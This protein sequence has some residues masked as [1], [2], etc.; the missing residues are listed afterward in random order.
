MAFDDPQDANLFTINS[1]TG[2]I[3]T[4]QGFEYIRTED[5]Q[6]TGQLTITEDISNLAATVKVSALDTAQYST[7][8]NKFMY[9]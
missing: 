7:Y 8:V 3:T 6:F 9:H 1:N 4:N 5:Y 2:D